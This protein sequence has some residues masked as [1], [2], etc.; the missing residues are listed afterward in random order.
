GEPALIYIDLHLVHEVTSPQAFD[1][2]RLAGRKVRRPDLTVATMDHNVPTWARSL[3]ITDEVSLRQIQV[4]EKNCQEFGI[5]LYD[6]HDPRQG[7]VHIIGPELGLSQPGTTIVCGDSH[8][9]THG[10]V[11]ALAFG[12]GTS[13]V[14]HVLATQCLVA[15]RPK[16]MEVRFDGTLAP[17]ATAKDMIL[18]LIGR[19]GT[20]G[21]PG[22]VRDYGGDA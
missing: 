1:G 7:I 4:L 3:P 11:G 16:T 22:H 6:L 17:R 8:T 18:A 15:S 21:P 5:T 14:E 2:L 10:A 9:S 12:I 13:A 20:A 19:I